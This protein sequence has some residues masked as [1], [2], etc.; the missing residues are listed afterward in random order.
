MGLFLYSVFVGARVCVC[1]CRTWCDCVCVFARVSL[2]EYW[3]HMKQKRMRQPGG[4]EIGWY[5]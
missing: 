1:V 2:S 4:E 3:A 5:L